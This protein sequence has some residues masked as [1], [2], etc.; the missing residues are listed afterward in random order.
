M[1]PH[2]TCKV[3]KAVNKT[4][5]Q[6]GIEWRHKALLGPAPMNPGRVNHQSYNL[7]GQN[8]VG[9]AG[10]VGAGGS[11]LKRSASSNAKSYK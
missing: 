11:S 5:R 9:W 2:P 7:Q 4:G 8:M 10:A 1:L 6:V 3:H